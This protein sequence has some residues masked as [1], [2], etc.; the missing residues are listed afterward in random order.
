MEMN[1]SAPT[2]KSCFEDQVKS[3]MLSFYHNAW[4]TVSSLR[5]LVVIYPKK[6]VP[7]LTPG[8]CVSWKPRVAVPRMATREKW[9]A[10]LRWTQAPL[11]WRY[12]LWTQMAWRGFPGLSGP[13]TGGLWP[14]RRGRNLRDVLGL[15]SHSHRRPSCWSP[16]RLWGESG[17]SRGC[18]SRG[19]IGFILSCLSFVFQTW[20]WSLPLYWS[21]YSQI[22][23]YF[24]FGF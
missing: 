14:G 13:W 17:R 9:G 24:P 20:V 4:N 15:N 7:A 19:Q 1:Y 11:C 3:S 8:S 21:F 18:K 23:L 22:D 5:I 12:L 10:A 6:K 2:W 16:S